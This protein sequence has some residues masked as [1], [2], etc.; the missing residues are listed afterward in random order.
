MVGEQKKKGGFIPCSSKDCYTV[1]LTSLLS[2]LSFLILE[3]L[4]ASVFCQWS[5]KDG[6]GPEMRELG[7]SKEPW[8]PVPL[9]TGSSL[10]LTVVLAGI[11]SC[12][13]HFLLWQ[14]FACDPTVL[15]TKWLKFKLSF[16]F[17]PFC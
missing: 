10:E 2:M 12:C 5:S 7:S 9:G 6:T 17:C 8:F 3:V 13:F 15:K 11:I 4:F 16:V 14:G 1:K